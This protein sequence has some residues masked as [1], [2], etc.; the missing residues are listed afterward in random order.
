MVVEM[1]TRRAGGH[2]CWLELLRRGGGGSQVGE[3]EE[4]KGRERGVKE[5]PWRGVLVDGMDR[6]EMAGNKVVATKVRP[7]GGVS[8]PGGRAEAPEDGED[9]LRPALGKVGMHAH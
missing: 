4:E 5:S 1:K 6:G 9:R 7:R 3:Y 2:G 8:W